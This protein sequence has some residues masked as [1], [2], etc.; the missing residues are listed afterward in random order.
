MELTVSSCA[1]KVFRN[2]DLN[3]DPCLPHRHNPCS[4]IIITGLLFLTWCCVPCL[5]HHAIAS[6]ACE[7]DQNWSPSRRSIFCLFLCLVVQTR[8]TPSVPPLGRQCADAA[9]R[10]SEVSSAAFLSSSTQSKAYKP[11]HSFF[12]HDF[13]LFFPVI[14]FVRAFSG[15]GFL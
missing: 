7:S 4:F 11:R 8:T 3:C 13:L 2:V 6:R 12:S 10:R 15:E 1:T 9:Q 5:P 14:L